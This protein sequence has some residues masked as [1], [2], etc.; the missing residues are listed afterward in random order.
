MAEPI[1]EK[2]LYDETDRNLMAA[3]HAVDVPAHLR[4]RLEQSLQ[5]ALKDQQAE[6]SPTPTALPKVAAR[7]ASPL[8]NRRS[9]IVAGIAAGVGSLAIGIRQFTQP[10]TQ[11]QLATISQSLLVQIQNADWQALTEA[12]AVAIRRSLHDIGFF[13]QVRNVTLDRM[14]TLQPVR[15]VHRAI[16]YDFGNKLTLLDLTIERG[17]QR[18]TRS[19]TELPSSRSD[20]LA[21]AMSSEQ[22]TLVFAGPASIREHILRAQTI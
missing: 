13:G 10:L 18:V 4:S 5:A 6:E 17:V 9:A 14:C 12:D 22:R 15:S 3:L 11:S 20:T 19:F 1:R 2:I 21:Y 7:K 8:W 16:A